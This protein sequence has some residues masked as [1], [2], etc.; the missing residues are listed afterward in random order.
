M[1]L[2]EALL[3]ALLL[4]LAGA[5]HCVGM[6]GA[7]SINLSLAVPQERRQ[8][9]LAM[10]R[11]QVLFS[12]GRLTS[13][14]VLG[15]LVAAGG[16]VLMAQLP[17][18]QKL[19]WLLAAGV[20]VL[21]GLYLLGRELGIRLLERAGLLLWRRLQP[22]LGRLM[23]V[24]SGPRALAVGLLWG[25]MPCGL[26]YSALALAAVSGGALQGMLVMLVFGLVT[27]V[28]VAGIGM[29]GNRFS[30]ARSPW[31]RRF[32]ALLAFL[33]AGWLFMHAA[34]FGDHG[35]HGTHDSHPPA[36]GDSQPAPMIDH[37]HHH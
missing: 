7:V 3:A 19:P 6:C 23:P 15:A 14:M 37:S 27:V 17:G 36:D 34:G 13:Y 30:L 16:D 32:G 35:G 11:W 18:G 25:F 10:A 21:I 24:D 29:L 12:A 28:P 26:V 5:G 2:T 31:L 8:G 9:N 22:L 4:A 1:A 33:F 20:M